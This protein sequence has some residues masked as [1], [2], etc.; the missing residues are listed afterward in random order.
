MSFY[1][2]LSTNASPLIS[3]S[4]VQYSQRRRRREGYTSG[5]A[6]IA[7]ANKENNKKVRNNYTSILFLSTNASSLISLS[8]VQHLQKRMMSRMRREVWAFHGV[9]IALTNKGNNKKGEKNLSF[10]FIFIHQHLTSSLLLSAPPLTEEEEEE[11][12]VI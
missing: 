10:H 3:L 12:T 9:R 8:L 11:R 5:G 2:I 6:P 1:F 4:P 7:L